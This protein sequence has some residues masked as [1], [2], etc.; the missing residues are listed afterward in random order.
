MNPSE[1][2]MIPSGASV[3]DRDND[4]P[5]TNRDGIRGPAPWTSGDGSHGRWRETPDF[6]DSVKRSP[7]R[8][9]WVDSRGL[10]ENGT[11]CDGLR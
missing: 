4:S 3:V 2:R 11:A 7:A 1:R 9:G 6:Y 8:V 10:K 5:W